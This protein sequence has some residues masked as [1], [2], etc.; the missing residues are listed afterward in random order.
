[1]SLKPYKTEYLPVKFRNNAVVVEKYKGKFTR[2]QIRKT[3]QALSDKLRHKNFNGSIEVALLYDAGWMQGP[4]TQVG[5]PIKLFSYDDYD[6]VNI[7]DQEHYAAFNIYICKNGPTAG[8]NSE[9]ND[10]LWFCLKDVLGDK[11]PWETGGKLKK[12]L[13]VPRKNKLDISLIPEIERKLRRH[14]INVTG[15]HVYTSPKDCVK[16][17]NLVLENGHYKLNKNMIIRGIAYQEKKPLLYKFGE[18]G[19]VVTFNG[20]KEK[21]INKQDFQKIKSN[22]VSSKYILIPFEKPQSGQAENSMKE[23]YGNFIK[24]AKGLKEVT[25]GKVNLFK[26]GTYAK[27]ALELFYSFNMDIK[28]DDILQDEAEWISNASYKAVIWTEKYNGP[29]FEY[30]INSDYPS[31]LASGGLFPIRRGSFK[32][33]SQQDF[34]DYLYIPFGIYRCIIEKSTD[35]NINKLF[36]WNARNYYTYIDLTEATKLGL[37]ITMTQDSQPNALQYSRDQLVTGN[38]LFKKYVELLYELK[39][40]GIEGSKQLLNILWGVLTQKNICKMVVSNNSKEIMNIQD[41]KMLVGIKPADNKNTIIE[42]GYMQKF[43]ETNYGRIAPFLLA[44]GRAKI[45]KIMQPHIESIVR[46]HTDSLLSKVPLNIPTSTEL[47]GLKL[48]VYKN[49][50]ILNNVSVTK[51]KL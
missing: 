24:V 38:S 35:K 40:K 2:E 21:L 45:S 25:D 42:I 11:I 27:T 19:T 15:D 7:E 36:V 12:F 30:D 6:G 48:T 1:M 43:Y 18:N 31:L 5:Q 29:G 3:T 32:C 34:D 23:Q 44:R 33:I 9:L 41:S 37:K 10:C 39:L 8:G 47:G 28:P 50:E 51:T 26:T 16:E 46:C 13:R 4:F 49:I 22:P 20:N 17:I 14:K